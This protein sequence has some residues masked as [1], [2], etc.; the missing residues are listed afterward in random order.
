MQFEFTE[1]EY[2]KYTVSC[3]MEKQEVLNKK[4]EV[5]NRFKNVKMP[6]FRKGKADLKS[7]QHVYKKEIQNELQNTLASEAVSNF[8]S[9]NNVKMIGN[10]SFSE[11]SLNDEFFT[12]TFMLHKTP[13]V[14]LKEYKNFSL[15]K[16]SL[17]DAS[18]LAASKIEEFRKSFGETVPFAEN[19]FVQKGDSVIIDYHAKHNNEIVPLLSGNGE[20]LVVGTS[21]FPEFDE[22]LFGMTVDQKREFS[23]KIPEDTPN[24]DLAG[25]TLDF[26]VHLKVGSKTVP[27][28]LD[29]ALAQ[30]MGLKNL[31]DLQTNVNLLI[32]QQ[33]EA[34][35]KAHAKKQILARL[36]ENHEF[37]I[38]HWLST[39]EAKFLSQESNTNWDSISNEN[40]RSLLARS[41]QNIRT[42]LILEKIRETEAEAQLTDQEIFDILK[43]NLSQEALKELATDKNSTMK[44]SLLM[45]RVKD[46]NVL[47]FIYKTCSFVE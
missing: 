41:E 46:E 21:P 36:L 31:E 3:K 19:D 1:P 20:V 10:P 12:C 14:E 15:P 38:P 39:A 44:I 11:V 33:I 29:D 25:K 2:C 5:L 9:E 22:N 18:D 47:D 7:I 28:A 37:E 30:K 16:P 34:S 4:P 13:S 6:G 26:S 8:I 23:L 17:P 24:K 32:S 40:K 45:G 35:K 42:T 43:T 27:A